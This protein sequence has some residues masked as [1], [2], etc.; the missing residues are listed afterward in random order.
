[1]IKDIKQELSALNYLLYEISSDSDSY[2]LVIIPVEKE[3]ELKEF[4]KQ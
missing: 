4:L 2:T 1:M 3:K